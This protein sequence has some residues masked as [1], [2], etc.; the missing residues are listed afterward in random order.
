MPPRDSYEL[1]SERIEADLRRRIAAGEWQSGEALPT[2]AQ[3][4]EHYR[5]SK[6]T[7]ARVLRK[8][9][10]EDSPLVRIRPRWGAYRA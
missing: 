3:L 10:A 1:P 5:T 7:V 9:A 8:F 2:L 6:T 4:S